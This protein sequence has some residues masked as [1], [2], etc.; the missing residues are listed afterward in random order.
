M[1]F[2]LL[3]ALKHSLKSFAIH[4]RQDFWKLNLFVSQQSPNFIGNILFSHYLMIFTLFLLKSQAW[5][6][7]ITNKSTQTFSDFISSANCL[8][9]ARAED[10][11]GLCVMNLFCTFPQKIFIYKGTDR[12]WPQHEQSQTAEGEPLP[13]APVVHSRELR[14]KCAAMCINLYGFFFSSHIP[15][16]YGLKYACCPCFW[17]SPL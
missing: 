6:S 2:S 17:M 8:L 14:G 1:L 13:D 11:I 10:T 5:I 7:L 3:G 9:E 12:S 15:L 16:I 4:S